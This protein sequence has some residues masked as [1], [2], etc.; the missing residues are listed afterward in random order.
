MPVV[1][2]T[3]GTATPAAR[4][5]DPGEPS[6]RRRGLL[7]VVLLVL[8][9][10]VVIAAVALA[11][12][13]SSPSPSRGHQQAS[14]AGASAGSSTSA[15]RTSSTRA[16]SSPTSSTSSTGSTTP[17]SSSTTAAAA[18]ASGDPGPTAKSFY[19]LAAE[20]HYPQAWALA[21]PAFQSQLGG[22]QSFQNTFASD[23]SITVNSLRTLSK[24][25]SS[26]TV[27]IS[28]TSVQTDGTQHCSG[29][30][31]LSPAGSTGGWLMHHIQ[32][33]CQ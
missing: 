13:A 8:L 24:S 15:S 18:A 27:A 11:S 23:R 12:G 14:G 30:V 25:A 29:T 31:Q 26:A 19:T 28:T 7:P 6:R 5:A 16:S 2:S 21:D 32:I 9:A 4:A 10:A 20:H 17:R 1:A 3:G 22:Y 33:G